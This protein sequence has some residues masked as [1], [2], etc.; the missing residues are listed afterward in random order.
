MRIWAKVVDRS[1]IRRF[2]GGREKEENGS[3]KNQARVLSRDL[4]TMTTVAK[5]QILSR[6][7]HIFPTRTFQMF[8]R[9]SFCGR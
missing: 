4:T 9:R 6:N 3:E 2:S 7:S 1:R 5:L 8:P